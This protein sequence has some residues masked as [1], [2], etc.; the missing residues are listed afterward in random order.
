[1]N[2]NSLAKD[3][4]STDV[5]L[6]AVSFIAT[7]LLFH[8][9]YGLG[10]L[11]P[12]DV[13]W[14]M[15]VRHDWGTHY[16]GWL[17]YRHEP[18]HWPLGQVRNYYYP[19]G[20]NIGFTDSIPLLAIP[21]KLFSAILPADFQYFGLWLFACH[22]LV[23]W[24]TIR[25]F[26][27]FK[28]NDLY[29]FFAVLLFVA[30]PI[31]V[32]R[33]LHPALC[34]HW[35]LLGSIY[36]YFRDPATD[37]TRKIMRSQWILFGLSTLI[38]PY[39]CFMVLGFVIILPIKLYYSDRAISRKAGLV[40]I[41]SCLF[42]L[43]LVWVVTGMI[44]LSKKENLNVEGAYGL[45]SLNLNSLYDG[46]GWS[47]IFPRLK[48]VSWHQY[49]GFMY[50]GA[51]IFLLLLVLLISRLLKLLSRS[52]PAETIS[53]GSTAKTG[54]TRPLAPLIV[55]VICYSL[56]AITHVVSIE[57]RVLF[58]V[59]IPGFLKSL[60][61][62]FRASA[63][64]FWVSYYLIFLTVII[65]VMRLKMPAIWQRLLLLF[66]LILQFYD[67]KTLL[68]FRHLSYGAYDIPMKPAWWELIEHSGQVI[69]Y[70]PFQ[71]SYVTKMDYQDF[72]Y[73][74]GKLKKPI[75]TG[76]V[77]RADNNA[78]SAYNDS[79]LNDLQ[80]ARVKDALYITNAQNL[81]TFSAVLAE[82]RMR[83]H[84][85][86][87]YCYMS[88]ATNAGGPL[89]LLA[90]SLDAGNKK[91]LDSLLATATP[92]S[93]KPLG[94]PDTAAG[95]MRYYIE[96]FVRGRS[97]LYLH[98]WTIIEGRADNKGD[99]LF[100]ILLSPGKI[101][102]APAKVTPRPDITAAY[103]GVYLDDAGFEAVISTN[104][105]D[106]G[107]YR[108]AIGLKPRGGS[109]RYQLTDSLIRIDAGHNVLR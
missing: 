42:C 5:R 79:L 45:Y 29:T 24:Y 19:I 82:R 69:L 58:K 33:G 3:P 1:M 4:R 2:A 17:F 83:L 93:Y 64:F 61:E 30:N 26:R 85:L 18:W 51:G 12:T 72:C 91:S 55:L 43:L 103:K 31:L 86:D 73:M 92:D 36:N 99:S 71:P 57:D 66:A 102:L 78:V 96:K 80:E 41:G 65:G 20:T 87:G 22:L 62:T 95:K 46:V 37:G 56:F 74:A 28:V 50:L 15:T 100:S 106:S 68:T 81:P 109:I 44:G 40:F 76:Y 6:Y 104:E 105:V 97:Y 101:Y 89:A 88:A 98:G 94:T 25:L 75:N 54:R 38:N 47:A 52:G 63:R 7:V 35:L 10:T 13:S 23:A 48:Q 8:I 21:F 27:L 90:D 34:A 77:A 60:G 53:D 11:V 70:P 49:E 39:L 59:P 32:Y 107:T 84:L 9:F 16:L 14:L 108:L 67:T